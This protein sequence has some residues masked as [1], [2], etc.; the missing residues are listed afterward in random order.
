[1]VRSL[2]GFPFTCS[3]KL[4]Q[5]GIVTEF[6]VQTIPS[7]QVYYEIYTYSPENTP[8]LL[9]AYGEFVADPDTDPASNVGIRVDSRASLAFYGYDG[10]KNRPAIFNKFYSIP[11]TSTIFPPT[12]G[13]IN[14]VLFRLS[15]TRRS[16][17]STYG[18]S[19]SHR[20]TN[21]SFLAE[22]YEVYRDLVPKLPP[23][24]SLIYA[25]QGVYPS[26]V[27]IANSK[28]GGNILNLVATPQNCECCSSF[29]P[30]FYTFTL[31][32]R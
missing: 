17:S 5:L 6:E 12:N 21:T 16:T 11:V 30:I 7:N 22:S 10:P 19:F 31:Y 15:Q 1:M 24:M 18:S 2:D 26:L 20:L 32:A 23:G 13:S 28:N 9:K 3:I 14:D 8:A 25:P 27:D 29:Y 4:T